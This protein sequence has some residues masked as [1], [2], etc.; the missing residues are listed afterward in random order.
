VSRAT[1]GRIW[2]ASG[3]LLLVGLV[4]DNMA[5]LGDGFWC[6]AA[7]DFVLRTHSLPTVDPFAFTS[8]AVPWVLHMPA[9]QV[10]GA[11]LVAHAGLRAFMAACTVPIAASACVLWLV[12]A[13]RLRAQAIVLPVV[14]LYVL[15]DADDISAR[16]QAFGD[17]GLV[18]LFVA[19]ERIRTGSRVWPGWPVLLGMAWANLHP[20][21][22]LG[23][24]LPLG[25][26][27]A[28][29]LE[30]A[31]L[32]SVPRRLVVFSGL[33]LAGACVNPYSVVLLID[34]VKLW[35]DP[36]TAGID[37]FRSPNFHSPGW[38]SPLVLAIVLLVLLGRQA[39]ARRARSDS[40]MLLAFMVAACLA[41]RYVTMLVAFEALLVAR[42]ASEEPLRDSPRWTT[43][44][45]LGFAGLQ[46]SYG[47]VLLSESKDPLRDVPAAA[48]ETID[49]LAL[50]DRVLNPYHWGGYLEW[51]WRG[52][53]KVFIDGRNQLFSNG[54]FDDEE[55]IASVAPQAATLLDLY[56][57]QTVLWEGGA[58]LD[59]ALAHDP[60]WREV[61]RD[62][63]AVVY[64]RR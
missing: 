55:L 34:V 32:G 31:P 20:S 11:W 59:Q 1:A 29:T 14:I 43:G 15:V 61:H 19:I 21:F 27:A 62:R 60:R 30:P 25:F 39:R 7:G 64:V 6:L 23:I 41:R 5:I 9:F 12:P 56:E 33:A 44:A 57:I 37:L 10:G 42:L 4:W 36:T 51:A 45:L 50:P 38:L 8:R 24:A 16:G 2:L 63:I 17:L 47:A 54:V 26:A 49:R 35:A 48:G 3:C 58:P 22:L 52:R 28:A 13:R 53:R 46:G 40:A 18:L